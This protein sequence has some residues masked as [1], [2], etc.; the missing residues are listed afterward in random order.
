MRAHQI[1]TKPVVTVGPE[2]T[3]V[4]AANIMLQKH[5][6]GLPVVDSSGELVGI[7]SEGDF[8]R[9]SEIGTQRKRG[10][11]LRF[12]LGPGKSAAD[13]VQ[14]HGRRV[15]E[16][17]TKDPL[18]ITEDTA[19]PEIVELMEKNNVKRLPVLHDG[20]LVGIVSRAN[21]LQAVASLARE[22]PDPTADDDHIRDRIIAALEKNDWC[23]FGLGVIVK[24]GIVHLSGVITEERARPAAIVAAENIEGVKKVHDHLCWVD[25][26]SGMYLNSPEDDNLAKAS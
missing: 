11:W 14:E 21:L 8:I 9:R 3:I 18:T 17:M 6:S 12:I 19:M 7:V 1:M 2:A 24:D 20:K 23:P 4:E 13:F 16:V 26:M 25:T 10:R 5:I 22:V 15:S